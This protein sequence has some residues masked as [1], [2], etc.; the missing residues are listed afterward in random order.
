MYG[1]WQTED[2]DVGEAVD[3][4]VPKNPHGNVYLYAESMMP[5]GCTLL[6]EPGLSLVLTKQL[7]IDAAKAVVGFT[8]KRGR[9]YPQYAEGLVVATENVDI[10]RMACAEQLE[11]SK[12]KEDSRNAKRITSNWRR[13]IRRALVY[14]RLK[15]GKV[16]E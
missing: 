2:V 15:K 14:H 3:G 10:L 13:L 7:G 5:R 6:D 4:I 16:G 9:S 12:E 11:V 8:F 1:P